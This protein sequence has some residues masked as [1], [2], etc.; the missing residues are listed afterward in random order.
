MSCF[1]KD[2]LN[3]QSCHP[4]K[5]KNLAKRLTWGMI[6][7]VIHCPPMFY[8]QGDIGRGSLSGNEQEALLQ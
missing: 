1:K 6:A 2:F 4:S 8:N 5:Y 7:K 3:D